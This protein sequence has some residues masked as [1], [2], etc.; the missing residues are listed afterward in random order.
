MIGNS[1]SGIIESASFKIPVI[2]LGDRQKNRISNQN[3]L[4]SS[5][6]DIN[7]NYSYIISKEFKK[8]IR[9]INNIYYKK[10]LSQKFVKIIYKLLKKTT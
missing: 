8:K 6:K 4:N 3:I 1:S 10:N 7:K 9:N 5:F 2:N